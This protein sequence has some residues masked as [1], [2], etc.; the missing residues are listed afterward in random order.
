MIRIKKQ[1]EGRH[2]PVSGAIDRFVVTDIA[3][4]WEKSEVRVLTMKPHVVFL[5]YT[6][7]QFI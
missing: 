3:P 6:Y 2:V 5:Y 4:G 7:S 1:T